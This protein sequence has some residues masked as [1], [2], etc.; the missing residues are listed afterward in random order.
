M[1]KANRSGR[2]KVHPPFAGE[3]CADPG[4]GAS[5]A[6]KD[7]YVVCVRTGRPAIRTCTRCKEPKPHGDFQVLNHRKRPGKPYRMPYCRECRAEA[8]ATL[9]KGRLLEKGLVSNHMRYWTKATLLARAEQLVAAARQARST[10]AWH[11]RE[12][13]RAYAKLGEVLDLFRNNVENPDALEEDESA[14]TLIEL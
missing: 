1:A 5:L 12:G 8:Q 14:P 10:G 11:G 6:M 2:R 9:R 4:C 7:G 3:V 13:I